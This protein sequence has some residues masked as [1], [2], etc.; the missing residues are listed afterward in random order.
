LLKVTVNH[1]VTD[2]LPVTCILTKCYVIS[3]PVNENLL[4][5]RSSDTVYSGQKVCLLTT[6]LPA[7]LIPYV[8]MDAQRAYA[9][10]YFASNQV[11]LVRA[12]HAYFDCLED[13]IRNAQ[14]T[15][16]LQTYIFEEDETGKRVANALIA[17]AERL[18]K[19]YVIVDGYASQ[20][21]SEALIKRYRKHGIYFRFF[22]SYFRSKYFYF[23]RRMHHKVV[24]VDGRHAL[25]GGINIGDHYNDTAENVAWLDWAVHVEGEVSRSLQQ[26]CEKRVLQRKLI[27]TGM[28]AVSG[29]TCDVFVRPRINDW[30]RRKRQITSS[31]LEM[32]LSAKSH[33]TLVSSY[34]I[35][36]KELRRHMEAAVG[37]GVKIRVIM[38]GISDVAISKYAERYMY[39]WM[40]RNK[41]E[42]WEYKRRVL[43]GKLST[44]DGQWV[45]VGSY[46]LN[47]ISAYASIELNLD[48]HNPAFASL[49]D[50]QLEDIIS[51]DC[52]QITSEYFSREQ[53]LWEKFLQRS[54]YDIFRVI[55]FLFT[56]YF[57]QRE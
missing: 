30:V 40:L 11:D 42:I 3:L 4:K 54:A 25:V 48:I 33:I 10:G 28:P 27:R 46:N 19:V 52:L 32:F 17:A 23:G 53:N 14:S 2:K 29:A 5:Y 12:G 38:A 56:F 26:I 41:V 43:H 8:I 39:Q 7:E 13:M 21:I 18:V 31:Y 45:T 6:N 51:Q 36:G 1:L 35:P 55:L 34:F 37:R 47:N 24:V 44:Y 9:K 49:V 16:H 57:K 15:I 20:N 50:Q 22:G